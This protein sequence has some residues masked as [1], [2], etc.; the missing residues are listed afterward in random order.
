MKRNTQTKCRMWCGGTSPTF[1][2]YLQQL[3][4][5]GDDCLEAVGTRQTSVIFIRLYTQQPR[6]YLRH[7]HAFM[8][9]T[10]L[11]E[12]L[13]ETVWAV[14]R[15]SSH[16]EVCSERTSGF[17]RFAL[18][19]RCVWNITVIQPQVG[20]WTALGPCCLHTVHISFVKQC[21]KAIS[22]L[23]T[24]LLSSLNFVAEINSV[25]FKLEM[26][27]TAMRDIVS[28]LHA[29]RADAPLPVSLGIFP[30]W[31]HF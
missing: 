31:L 19:W 22:V 8:V 4:I 16:P 6:R 11:S 20:I 24:S 26:Q 5:Q 3:Y 1:H 7:L 13:F 27:N 17:A 30:L 15:K 2:R 12:T 28:V 14:S 29:N 25:G 21:H 9:T 10:F 23:L 18:V